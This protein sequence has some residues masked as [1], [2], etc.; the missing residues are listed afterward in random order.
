MLAHTQRAPD[1]AHPAR[2]RLLPNASSPLTFACVRRV[3]R[4]VNIM[5]EH[6]AQPASKMAFF[7]DRALPKNT[8][9]TLMDANAASCRVPG[10]VVRIFA[11]FASF[12]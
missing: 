1:P 11:Y 8:L 2:S 12:V 5:R 6:Y 9:I 3:C 4:S 10:T 7:F